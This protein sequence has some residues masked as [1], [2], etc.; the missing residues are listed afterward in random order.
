LALN[1]AKFAEQCGSI[2]PRCPGEKVLKCLLLVRSLGEKTRELVKALVKLK[3]L[4]RRKAVEDFKNVFSFNVLEGV[5]VTANAVVDVFL[6][7]YA[8]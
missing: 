2:F 3:H 7:N 1:L 4:G 8:V 6:W 5:P